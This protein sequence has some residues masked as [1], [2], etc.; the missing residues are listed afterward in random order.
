MADT[1]TTTK[2]EFEF[3]D[4]MEIV[5]VAGLPPMTESDEREMHRCL[6]DEY[7][8]M[9]F[10]DGAILDLFRN[11]FYRATHSVWRVRGE[12]YV[13]ELIAEV[14]GRWKPRSPSGGK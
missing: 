2:K 1:K 8:R 6:V 12:A 9:G 3:D 4:P 10:G 5:G 13:I 14:R 11:P 7:V